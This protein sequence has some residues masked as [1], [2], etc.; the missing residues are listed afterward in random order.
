MKTRTGRGKGR[1]KER[2]VDSKEKK[3]RKKE[4]HERRKDVVKR[5]VLFFTETNL[6]LR[7]FYVFFSFLSD[8]DSPITIVGVTVALS[9]CGRSVS[10]HDDNESRNEYRHVTSRLRHR[11]F[12]LFSYR[13]SPFSQARTYP[14]FFRVMPELA[15]RRC[16]VTCRTRARSYLS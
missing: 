12:L 7:L 10:W 5:S 6:L 1:G 11:I 3:R 4:L 13:I 16:S 9:G 8:V 2:G 15:R 14:R